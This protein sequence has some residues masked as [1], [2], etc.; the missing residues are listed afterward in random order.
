MTSARTVGIVRA[1]S[2]R[3]LCPLCGDVI[4]VYEPVLVVGEGTA[5]TS[6]LAREPHL[7]SGEDVVIHRTCGVDAGILAPD[8]GASTTAEPCSNDV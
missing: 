5:R 6:S 7:A 2:R 3:L 4:G 1:V 8:D